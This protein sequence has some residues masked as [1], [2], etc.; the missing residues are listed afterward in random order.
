M[1]EPRARVDPTVLMIL[2][3]VYFAAGKLGL[4][5]AFV[6]PSATAIWP[7][8]G[9]ALA[10]FLLRGYPAW[11][12]VLLGAF[13]VNMATAGGAGT[14]IGIAVGNTLE[15]LAGAYLVN[16]FAGGLRAFDRPRQVFKFVL[17]AALASTTISATLGVTTLLLGGLASPRGLGSVWLTW[18]LGDLGG[19]IIIA[20]LLILWGQERRIDLSR[21][22]VLEAGV[23]LLLIL[24]VGRAVFGGLG[25]D[26]P[27]DFPL[28]FLSIP[29][30]LW[31]AFRFSQRETATASFMLAG[32]AIFSL[33]RGLGPVPRE[34]RNEALLLLQAF[35]G[36]T[37][38]TALSVAALV[39]EQRRARRDLLRHSEEL[40][41]S[42]ADLERF[43][44]VASHDLQE[45]VR[46]VTNYTELLAKRYEGSLDHDAREFIKYAVEGAARMRALINGLLSYSRISKGAGGFGRADCEVALGTALENL[47][48]AIEESGAIITHDPLPTVTG[49]EFQLALLLQNLVGN[50]IKFRRQDPPRIHVGFEKEKNGILFH[51]RDNG[52]GIERSHLDR[53][54]VIFQRLHRREEFPGTGIGLA[55]CKRIVEHHGGKIA[56]H[57]DPGRGST[58]SFFLPA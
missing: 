15:G 33:V 27:A 12:G 24:G 25:S 23:L 2:A 31:P 9:I 6:N 14:S 49:D 5:L 38:V 18:W 37:S 41:R 46:T 56:V 10:A 11:P 47:R 44:Y 16:R 51:V 54:F 7:P 29:L 26:R 45:P 43:A 19:D 21:G 28:A 34:I 52:I 13:L 40:A 32:I 22:Q 30:L 58:F 35:L 42:N 3:L 48:L 4:M 20:P 53:I 57:S 50:A 17:L 36:V 39:S 55:I 1:S 8:T